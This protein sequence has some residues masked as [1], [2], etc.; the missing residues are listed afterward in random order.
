[1]PKCAYIILAAVL[2]SSLVISTLPYGAAQSQYMVVL[3]KDRNLNPIAGAEVAVFSPP[4]EENWVANGFTNTSGYFTFDIS[5]KIYAN[6]TVF[7]YVRNTLVAAEVAFLGQA[8]TVVECGVR[9]LY[10][11]IQSEYGYPLGDITVHL[12][13]S[14]EYQDYKA[15]AKSDGN[16]IVTFKNMPITNYTISLKWTPTNTLMYVFNHDL[17]VNDTLKINLPVYTLSCRAFD[18]EGNML[19]NVEFTVSNEQYGTYIGYPSEGEY[20]V[21]VPSGRYRVIAKYNNMALEREVD[22]ASNV[23]VDFT[24]TKPKS[25]ALNIRV[26]YVD[27]STVSY[28]FIEVYDSSNNLVDALQ[29]GADAK[30]SFKLPKGSY[31][32]VAKAGSN[33]ETKEVALEEDTTLKITLPKP[34]T[35]TTQQQQQQASILPLVIIV[36]TITITILLVLFMLRRVRSRSF[37]TEENI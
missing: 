34:P 27:N 29:L 13:W 19:D 5:E 32:V 30:T 37:P 26:Y 25:Y 18:D 24:F 16:G 4:P 10:I 8:I 14:R 11:N 17:A 15:N 28:A 2:L 35:S 21:R 7:V 9:D 36:I 33:M 23:D 20:W 6:Y 31:R 22:L 1:M 12:N 3:V